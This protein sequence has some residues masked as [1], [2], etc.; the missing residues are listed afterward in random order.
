M[1]G[2]WLAVCVL[3]VIGMVRSGVRALIRWRART[4]NALGA[5]IALVP[6][7]I[8]VVFSALKSDQGWGG[9]PVSPLS[10]F[11]KREA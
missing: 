1:P 9:W 6:V 7:A 11:I 5:G 10:A 2:L 8:V 3:G 4:A